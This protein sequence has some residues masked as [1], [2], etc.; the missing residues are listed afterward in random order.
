MENIYSAYSGEDADNVI[1]FL[2][3][4]RLH[5]VIININDAIIIRPN[6]NKVIK[7]A[8]PEE[9]VSEAHKVLA[10]YIVIPK[11]TNEERPKS[12]VE[13]FAQ[14]FLFG[15]IVISLVIILSE[16]GNK[17]TIVVLVF[18]IAAF[19]SLMARRKRKKEGQRG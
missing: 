18:L 17:R 12:N 3:S 16:P 13:K 7:I 4:K 1:E 19:L 9:E 2:E 10:D 11:N 14:Y 6:I 15:S 8:V 5:P